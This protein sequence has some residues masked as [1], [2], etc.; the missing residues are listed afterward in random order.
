[1]TKRKNPLVFYHGVCGRAGRTRV[2]LANTY[3]HKPFLHSILT[4]AH[5]GLGHGL[6]AYLHFL[7]HRGAHQ[8]FNPT[9]LSAHMVCTH[10]AC[11]YVNMAQPATHNT[12]HATRA[13]RDV[14]LIELP[15]I[16][17]RVWEH[18]PTPQQV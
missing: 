5:V 1:M 11:S 13:D 18:I 17:T 10:I 3:Y 12:Q 6:V 14:F 7:K 15:H 2:R 16:S 4:H 9:T 8:K